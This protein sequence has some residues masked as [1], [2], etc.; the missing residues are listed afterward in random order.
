MDPALEEQPPHAGEEP[1]H[2]RVGHEP[3]H[4]AQPADPEHEEHDPAQDRHDQGRGDHREEALVDAPVRV[5]GRGRGEDRQHRHARSLDAPDHSARAGPPRED[6]ERQHGG[7][8]VQAD[9]V[10]QEVVEEA[11]EHERSERDRE[12]RLDGTDDQAGRDQRRPSIGSPLLGHAPSAPRDRD[13]D[14]HTHEATGPPVEA[15]ARQS[16]RSSCVVVFQ[17]RMVR[18]R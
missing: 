16:S 1:S 10:G 15:A 18:F 11:D 14:D 3:D 9:A 6:R 13:A 17:L 5:D 12:D 2:D 8:Q 7:C 4:V